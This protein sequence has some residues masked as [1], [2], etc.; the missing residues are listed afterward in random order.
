M[1]PT[2]ERSMGGRRCRRG[3]WVT[4]VVRNSDWEQDRQVE[5][6]RLQD[7]VQVELREPVIIQDM[8]EDSE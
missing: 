7:R 3:A 6:H 8:V 4:A 5:V 2:H 1:G